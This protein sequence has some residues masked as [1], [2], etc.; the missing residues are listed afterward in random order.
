MAK[1]KLDLKKKENEL[2]SKKDD[3]EHTNALLNAKVKECDKL[4]AERDE[5]KEMKEEN[6]KMA[7]E[8]ARYVY[9]SKKNDGKDKTHGLS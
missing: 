2:Q 3:H 8:I 9:Y 4:K 6:L 1:A 7:A 5:Q